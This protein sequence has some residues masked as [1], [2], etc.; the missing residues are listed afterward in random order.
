[1]ADQR[2]GESTRVTTQSTD[3]MAQ[4]ITGRDEIW[5]LAD[6]YLLSANKL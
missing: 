4:Q 1:M 6:L 3:R 5:I 2:K